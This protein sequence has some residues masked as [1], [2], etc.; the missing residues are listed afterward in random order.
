MWKTVKNSFLLV[1]FLFFYIKSPDF[2]FV[3]CKIPIRLKLTMRNVYQIIFLLFSVNTTMLK[4]F[5]ID[6][7][8]IIIKAII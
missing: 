7:E 2:F 8:L 3:I 1:V 4:I 6:I 5:I